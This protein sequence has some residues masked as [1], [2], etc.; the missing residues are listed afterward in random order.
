M[1]LLTI[2]EAKEILKISLETK[3]VPVLVGDAGIGKTSIV[4]QV[5]KE[6]GAHLV[7]IEGNLLKEGEIG[8]LP[9][10][11]K[12]E[13]GTV[14]IYARHYKLQDIEDHKHE[15][16]ILFIDEINRCNTMVQQELM[17]LILQREINGYKLPD[18][19]SL[20]GAM[21]PTSMFEE[22][23]DRDYQTSEMDAAIRD[24][25]Y[26]MPIGADFDSWKAWAKS[27]NEDDEQNIDDDIIGFLANNHKYLNQPEIQTAVGPTPRSW[28]RFSDYWKVLKKKDLTGKFAFSIGSG[29][30]GTIAVSEFLHYLE[31][32]KDAVLVKPEEVFTRKKEVPEEVL[33]K[34]K[35][36][37]LAALQNNIDILLEY[38]L[39]NKMNP[40][41]AAQLTQ[42]LEIIP[43]DVRITTMKDL[44]DGEKYPGF[45]RS[46]L[47]NQAFLMLH[48]K[49]KDY[50]SIDN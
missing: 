41:R 37:N 32:R 2:K 9:V 44:F 24:R 39:K 23:Q 34:L 1:A 38:L 31:T 42:V 35:T 29:N 28:E 22:F 15:K 45:K 7:V 25:L 11:E 14:T 19:V 48:K 21:N 46:L 27:K 4:K 6:I 20:I 50:A 33:E 40:T 30:V 17:N 49:T 16:I 8:G 26:W 5:A 18:T 47:N 3:A 36:D 13:N 10:I 43:S 12:T